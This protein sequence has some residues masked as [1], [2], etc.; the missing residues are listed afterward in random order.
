VNHSDSQSLF[1][2]K[3]VR[4]LVPR[5]KRMLDVAL[6]LLMLPLVLPVAV[7]IGVAV[8]LVSPGPILFRQ[9]RVGLMGRRFMCLKFRTMVVH[10]ETASH[11]GHLK[12]LMQTNAPMLKLDKRG[13]S[14]I[15]P[16]GFILRSSAMD[17]L[18]QLINVLIGDMSLVGPRPCLPYESAQYQAWQMER[19]DTLPGLTG[20]WQVSGKNNT[21][22]N[23]MME[24][25]IK[26]AREKT[27]WL[28]L[29]IMLKTPAVIIGQVL[30][31]RLKKRGGTLPPSPDARATEFAVGNMGIK[32]ENQPGEL[33][34]ETQA[35]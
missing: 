32:R 10:A 11:Q 9:E 21:T 18:P 7:V 25:D 4:V 22:F 8:A 28:D 20:L 26:Y 2:A 3:P 16:F 13:D 30:E 33:R 29:A 23:E 31:S 19:F 5:W 17:E 24:L 34:A 14:R 15:I 12:Q 35:N 27:L 6:I 1:E